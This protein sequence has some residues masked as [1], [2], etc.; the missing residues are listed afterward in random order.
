[1]KV[2]FLKKVRKI[3][4]VGILPLLMLSCASGSKFL[5]LTEAT[6]SWDFNTWL[7]TDSISKTYNK[8]DVLES[9]FIKV[10]ESNFAYASETNRL[11]SCDSVGNQTYIEEK[12]YTKNTCLT[13]Y[14][15]NKFDE[16]NNLSY[17]LIHEW[18]NS[19]KAFDNRKITYSY[20]K[21]NKVITKLTQKLDSTNKNHANFYNNSFENYSKELF[22]YDSKN[23]LREELYM[24]WNKKQAAF[25]NQSRK[26]HS[27]DSIN[28]IETKSTEKWDENKDSFIFEEK[29]I[30]TFNE[31][32][33]ITSYQIEKWNETDS[34]FEII[35][36]ES[37][38]YDDERKE[39]SIT[40]QKMDKNK[41]QLINNNQLL[42][43]YAKNDSIKRR[44]FQTWNQQLNK[45]ENEKDIVF[46]Y[47]KNNMQTLCLRRNWNS[48]LNEF[49]AE[50]KITTTY[51]HSQNV[52]MIL[53]ENWNQNDKTYIYHSCR[54][55]TYKKAN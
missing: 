20:D 38:S 42:T 30:Q 7:N 53:A 27:N 34:D 39:I 19:N 31:N 50:L 29:R 35:H 54:K 2:Q 40:S 23:I 28:R 26:I 52:L 32:N 3:F 14:W 1:M 13:S 48:K 11:I 4:I 25:V 45:W 51:D 41:K 15:I 24:I 6:Y 55:Y 9:E 33:L 44:V 22:S 43:E 47:N 8:N 10:W 17:S 16:N 49:V 12:L 18:N 46:E 37:Y 36:I 5:T 21:G